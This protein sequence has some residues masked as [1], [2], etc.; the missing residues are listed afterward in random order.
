MNLD[1]EEGSDDGKSQ[2]GATRID[3]DRLLRRWDRHR[4]YLA[5]AS[6]TDKRLALS[7][8]VIGYLA[9]QRP[10]IDLVTAAW[11][12][13]ASLSNSK[14]DLNPDFDAIKFAVRIIRNALSRRT[15]AEAKE[16]ARLVN[17]ASIVEDGLATIADTAWR[18]DQRFLKAYAAG[19]SISVWGHDIRYRVYTLL[20]CAERAAKLD[21]D[22]VE[23]GVDRGGTARCVMNYLGGARFA[24]RTFYLFDTFSGIVRSQLTEEEKA[25]NRAGEDRYPD[26]LDEVRRTFVADSFVRIVPG[27]VPDTLPEYKG[28]R[29]AYLHID[30]NAALPECAAFEHFWPMLA[31][32]APVIFDDYGFPNHRV[33]REALDKVA[34]KL[35][36]T[37]MMLPT[38]QGLAWK[39]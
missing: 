17:V 13:C 27:A 25:L 2:L 33:Q 19:A 28:S 9:A 5:N 15:A 4:T 18:N 37:I 1:T 26:V 14:V 7:N 10:N 21:G 38:C 20:K 31:P 3:R 35:G 16:I 23:C 11:Q 34:E 6:L 32:S 39:T 24:G 29:I 36:T 30:M 12:A 8:S 22:F